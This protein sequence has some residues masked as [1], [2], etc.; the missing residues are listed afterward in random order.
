MHLFEIIGVN[1]LALVLQS[2]RGVP[3]TISE[4][5]LA[6][7]SRSLP[8]KREICIKK[9]FFFMRTAVPK[10]SLI[11]YGLLPC[12]SLFYLLFNKMNYCSFSYS[13]KKVNEIYLFLEH[14]G[15]FGRVMLHIFMRRR[16]Q[17]KH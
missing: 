6:S 7:F 13:L 5:P 8:S 17:P 10:A 4:M 15:E 14:L 11:G 1:E 3:K 12:H 2:A 16:A 9:E